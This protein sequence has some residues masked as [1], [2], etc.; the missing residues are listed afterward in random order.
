VTYIGQFNFTNTGAVPITI[1]A[2]ET[3]VIGA[4]FYD[5]TPTLGT[6]ILPGQTILV[7][8]SANF[9]MSGE[10][11]RMETSCDT[12]KVDITFPVSEGDPCSGPWGPGFDTHPQDLTISG[13]PLPETPA[14][15]NRYNTCGWSAGLSSVSYEG[16][17]IWEAYTPTV[18]AYKYGAFS[19]G[20]L[21][22]YYSGADGSGTLIYTVT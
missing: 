22:D 11:L 10:T 19:D 9:S 8:V 17:S 6:P 21:G 15:V 3:D 5:V 12:E 13:D 1:A 4:V 2:F 16:D 7:A 14:I 18:A 20:P